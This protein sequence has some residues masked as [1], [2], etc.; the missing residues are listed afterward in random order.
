[1][2]ESR[3]MGRVL[4]ALEHVVDDSLANGITT[5]RLNEERRAFLRSSFLAAGA[6][7]ASGSGLAQAS[8][9]RT[10]DGAADAKRAIPKRFT[11]P[12]QNRTIETNGVKLY[13]ETFGKPSDPVVLLIMGATA[14]A[15]WWPEDFCRQL[16]ARGRYV[17]RYD[18]RDTGRSTK[19]APGQIN[20]SVED[21]AD[22]AIGV[23]QAYGVGRAHLAGMSLGGFLSQ[24]IAL[25]Y[26]NRVSSLTLIAS[27]P[28]AA[29]DPDIP[30]M[31]PK[32]LAHHMKSG[33]LDWSNREL[34]VEHVVEAW[35]LMAG[36]AHPFDKA[37]I[38]SLAAQDFDRTDNLL[39]SMNHA[40][41]AGGEQWFNRLSEVKVPAL[42]VHGT[43]DPVLNYAHG[44]ALAKNLPD[45]TL[46]TLKG[47]G[48]ELHRDDWTTIINAVDRHTAI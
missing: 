13:T 22:D 30:A 42:V 33:E 31:D 1:M 10:P 12:M 39:T 26:P 34:V 9:K 4:R 16:A 23:L 20:Y 8:V 38:R 11:D 43:E 25:K 47:T 29:G 28:L 32:V 40:L 21:L 35:R 48:H 24:M 15:I 36:T 44:V 46:L 14:S 19:N 18:H 6:A 3:K 41:L 27:E 17:I 5:D 7:L 2:N 45:A 37:A